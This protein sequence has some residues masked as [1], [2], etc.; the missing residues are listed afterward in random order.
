MF[1][2]RIQGFVAL[3]TLAA[4][5]GFFFCGAAFAQSNNTIRSG[6]V[7]EWSGFGLPSV[8][9]E[10]KGPLLDIIFQD[11]K[12]DG[13]WSRSAETALGQP[14]LQLLELLKA[15]KWPDAMAYLKAAKPDLNRRD[16]TGATPLS[17]VARV[18]ELDL[19][20]EMLRQGADPD[21]LGAGGFTPVG[22]AAFAGHE[23]V[24][25]EL[26]RKEARTDVA[27][28]SGQYPLHLACVSGEL[29]SIRQ[30]APA[31]PSGPPCC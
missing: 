22:A 1:R 4:C 17:I 6:D 10:R 11:V 16:D 28:S 2:V 15:R 3:T 13:P 25:R 23:L 21:M 9:P 5:Q 20:K 7:S 29:G 14:E 24:L 18:G 19:V 26:L 27:M 8:E 31:K 30:L 12:Q